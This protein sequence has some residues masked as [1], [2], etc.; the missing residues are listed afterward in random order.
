MDTFQRSGHPKNIGGFCFSH[1]A[2]QTKNFVQ[3]KNQV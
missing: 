1:A 2:L 3:G